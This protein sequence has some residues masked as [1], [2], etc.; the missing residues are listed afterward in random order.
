MVGAHQ[1]LR[2]R[3][4]THAAA[5]AATAVATH[6]RPATHRRI[7][8]RAPANARQRGLHPQAARKARRDALVDHIL[9]HH[10]RKAEVRNPRGTPRTHQNVRR[11]QVAV[12]HP[13]L[14]RVG[15]RTAHLAENRQHRIRGQ[16]PA[17]AAQK[18]LQRLRGGTVG[19]HEVH[20]D[21]VGRTL[22]AHVVHTHDVPMVQRRK[23]TTLR[24]KTIPE[25]R[26]TRK[27]LRKNL[28]GTRNT[29]QVVLAE[30]HLAHRTRAKTTTNDV[31][32]QTIHRKTPPSTNLKNHA[33]QTHQTCQTQQQT[34]GTP[35]NERVRR[36][37][38]GPEPHGTARRT[39]P[40][41]PPPHGY[42]TGQ[43]PRSTA[44][45]RAECAQIA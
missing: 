39:L 22:D 5:A 33:E 29:Q 32:P 8:G 35:E 16:T 34:A 28:Q 14:M 45:S 25:T 19:R 37:A 12:D 10:P 41:G 31:M 30:P 6:R 36:A 21:E 43:D 18:L 11:L 27:T 38:P 23:D 24:K 26:R 1:R 9:A 20:R 4:T 40:C 2:R 3:T 7:Q 42:G 44:R 15:H 13:A 17:A